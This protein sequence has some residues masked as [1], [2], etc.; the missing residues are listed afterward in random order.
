VNTPIDERSK[1][2]HEVK[3]AAN[4]LST[5]DRT[6]A[7]AQRLGRIRMRQKTGGTVSA[8]SR[9]CFRLACHLSVGRGGE[10][11]RMDRRAKPNKG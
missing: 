2:M 10:E 6:P 1:I 7:I 9:G 8:C 3:R 11:K 5:R 4:I